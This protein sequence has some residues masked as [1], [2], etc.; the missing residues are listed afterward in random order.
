MRW[1]CG[2]GCVLR[3]WFGCVSMGISELCHFGALLLE[4]AGFL[5]VLE[6]MRG[7]TV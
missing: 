4:M 3:Q 7:W 6:L 5:S 2:G 1:C